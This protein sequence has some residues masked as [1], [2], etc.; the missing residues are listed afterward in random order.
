MALSHYS[1]SF[2]GF[3]VGNS[4]LK[5]SHDRKFESGQNP[6]YQSYKLW[7]NLFHFSLLFICLTIL[8]TFDDRTHPNAIAKGVVV[9]FPLKILIHK[10]TAPAINNP[11]LEMI[12][13]LLS[14]FLSI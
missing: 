7:G 9:L 11:K 6:I 2:F 14:M 8:K 10:K 1:T 3:S 5:I 13:S 4:I 12:K